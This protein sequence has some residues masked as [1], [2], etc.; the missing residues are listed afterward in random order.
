MKKFYMLSSFYAIIGIVGGVFYREFTKFNGFDGRTTLGFVHTH[1]LLLGMFFFLILLLL[2]K[3]FEISKHPKCSA[4]LGFYNVGLLTT[5]I[6]LVVRGIFQVLNITLS[7]GANSAI[8]G[9][10]GTGHIIMGIGLILFF[11]ILKKQAI[12]E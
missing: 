5:I 9:V 11:I 12:K 1:A 7:S 3:Q 10:A 4:F 8:S 6:M 2:E